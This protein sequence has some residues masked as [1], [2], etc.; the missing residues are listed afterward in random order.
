MLELRHF[1]TLTTLRNTGSLVDAARRLHLTQSAL[2]HQLRDLEDRLDSQLFE[3]K[4]KPIRFTRCGLEILKCADQVLSLVQETERTLKQMAGGQHGRLNMAIECHSCFEWLM[5]TINQFR[6][7]W[8]DVEIDLSTAFHFEPI[9]ALLNGDID[10][11]ITSDRQIH[12]DLLYQP[13]FRY[14]SMLAVANQHKLNQQDYVQPQD[15]QNETII[16]YPIARNRLDVFS[17][18]LQPAGIEPLNCREAELTLMIVQLVA[19]GRGVACLPNWALQ[20]Y[21]QNKLIS[22]IPL[23]REGLKPTLY[24]AHRREPQ[25]Q[26]F[27][28]DFVQIG[29]ENCLTQLDGIEAV[30]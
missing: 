7:Q 20:P 1:K 16:H 22:A 15:L 8:P 5:P 19:S 29:L 25:Q 9:P 12:P 21:L 6:E 4:T 28:A 24:A 17:Q 2:S 11:V 14:Q 3:R 27:L 26:H 10:M 18:F 30:K 13:L 23:G